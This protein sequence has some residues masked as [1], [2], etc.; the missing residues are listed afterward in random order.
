M[1]KQPVDPLTKERLDRL[2]RD[3]EEQL[4]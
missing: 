2:I 1:A 4:Q 3:L